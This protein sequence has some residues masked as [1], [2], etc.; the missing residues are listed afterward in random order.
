MRSMLKLTLR[1]YHNGD[2]GTVHIGVG[3]A[4]WAT[5]GA[6]A[7]V[8]D[9]RQAASNI[10][11]GYAVYLQEIQ[12]IDTDEPRVV[13]LEIPYTALP[14][15]VPGDRIDVYTAW[16]KPGT[17]NWHVWGINRSDAALVATTPLGKVL[18]YHKPRIATMRV[19][20]AKGTP[21]V[22]LTIAPLVSSVI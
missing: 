9:H 12:G 6:A 18:P 19:A 14:G 3:R 1:P 7:G 13:E 21:R 20:G 15:V 16:N 17:A 8:N 11:Y 22:D 5:F 10:D 2:G 4:N